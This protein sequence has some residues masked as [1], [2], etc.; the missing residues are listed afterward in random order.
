M[1]DKIRPYT[2]GF[3]FGTQLPHLGTSDKELKQLQQKHTE[4]LERAKVLYHWL[5]AEEQAEVY[6]SLSQHFIPKTAI[7]QEREYKQF[8][9]DLRPYVSA[10]LVGAA[11]IAV[12]AALSSTV[13]LS[14]GILGTCVYFA[15][16]ADVGLANMIDPR[17]LEREHQ[18][19]YAESMQSWKQ[20]A[21]ID[22]SAIDFVTTGLAY[23]EQAHGVDLDDESI[24]PLWTIINREEVK[25]RAEQGVE[26]LQKKL[27]D[28][29]QHKL[30]T[31]GDIET[32]AGLLGLLRGRTNNANRKKGSRYLLT[33]R[34]E[35]RFTSFSLQANWKARAK[36]TLTAGALGL[37]GIS[38][39]WFRLHSPT[40]ALALAT[41]SGLGFAYSKR[42]AIKGAL[43]KAVHKLDLA[44]GA[45]LGPCIRRI[46]RAVHSCFG[47]TQN[48]APQ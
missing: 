29:H 32:V 34:E 21:K 39:G 27:K 16:R 9:R 11:A 17:T 8:E 31:Q 18:D 3:L 46:D 14:L 30:S 36:L 25:S 22:A 2:P 13:S 28:E 26:A 19:K 41:L 44:A 7:G 33:P 42:A 4:E 1:L 48:S 23:L 38:Q 20:I 24:Q 12:S 45:L 15:Q 5:P 6:G 43:W 47:Q 37:F 35:P 40:S 10:T